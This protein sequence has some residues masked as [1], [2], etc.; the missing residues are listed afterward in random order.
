MGKC[1]AKVDTAIPHRMKDG[2]GLNEHLIREAYEAGADTVL[3]CD[4]GIAAFSQIEYANSLGMTVVVT[5]HHEVPYEEKDAER[6]YLIPP[7]AAVVDPKQQDCH[8]PFPEI[9]GAVV[10]YKL[11]LR[12]SRV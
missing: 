5:D 1:G 10:A 7:A 6:Q 3:T 9:C 4:N 2:Y 12:S 8:Y 11:V